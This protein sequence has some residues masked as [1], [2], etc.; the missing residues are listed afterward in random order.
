MSYLNDAAQISL[1]IPRIPEEPASLQ[2]RILLLAV[3]LPEDVV[4][5]LKMSGRRGSVRTFLLLLKNRSRQYFV[6]N[7]HFFQHPLC[8]DGFQK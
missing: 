4:S 5:Y 2:D 3:H 1:K 6:L 8:R 7:L